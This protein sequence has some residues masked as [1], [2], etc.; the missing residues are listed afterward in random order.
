MD[1]SA[2][3]QPKADTNYN[4]QSTIMKSIFNN[5]KFHETKWNNDPLII[6]NEIEVDD[7]RCKVLDFND[8]GEKYLNLIKVL[9]KYNYVLN[10]W[11]EQYTSF[12]DELEKQKNLF[13]IKYSKKVEVEIPLW[14]K[15][16]YQFY[17]TYWNL[18]E[19]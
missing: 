13:L 18:L 10:D 5:R 9:K 3:W 7:K 12:C 15:V 8:K 19:R 16:L 14:K 6:E 4:N 11:Y 17:L 1:F 2:F